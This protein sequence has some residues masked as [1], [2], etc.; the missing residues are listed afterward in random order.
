MGF[1]DF[2]KVAGGKN[3]PPITGHEP[4]PQADLS[5]EPPDVVHLPDGIQPMSVSRMEQNPVYLARREEAALKA[6]YGLSGRIS[7]G[8]LS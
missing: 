6:H 3:K 1:F 2:L 4:D 5:A 7:D 8:D